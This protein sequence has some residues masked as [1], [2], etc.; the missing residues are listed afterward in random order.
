M[1]ANRWIAFLFVALWATGFLGAR[2][3]M[4]WAEPFSFLFLRF[5]IAAGLFAAAMAALKRPRITIAAAIRSAMVGALM[6]GL[7]LGGVFWAIRNGM[8]SGM[9][10][11]LVGLQ[12]VLT[13]LLAGPVLGETIAARQWGGLAAGLVGVAM[14][15]WPKLDV[16]GA[17]VTG[18]TLAACLGAVFAMALGTIWQKR[19]VA[20]VDLIPATAMQYVGGAAVTGLLAMAFETWRFQW[21]GELAFALAWLVLVLSVGAILLLMALIESGAVAGV[22]SLFYLV[23]G[24]TAI[25]AWA[26]FGESLNALQIAGMAVT[27]AAVAA[28]TRPGRSAVGA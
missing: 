4:P 14:V 11:L 6:H 24:V 28:A 3:A 2:L 1:T 25:L 26:L 12:P 22:A 7:Y 10:A 9:S 17:G 13:A 23:P 8:P 27:A 19:F 5:A 15:L 18:A 21:T 16:S 20:G